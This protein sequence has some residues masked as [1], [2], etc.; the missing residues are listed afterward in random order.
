M[1]RLFR[2]R[3]CCETSCCDTGCSTGGCGGTTGTVVTPAPAMPK[4]AGP[5]AVP[6]QLPKN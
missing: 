2:N 6:K 4:A 3:F 1:Q 5:I